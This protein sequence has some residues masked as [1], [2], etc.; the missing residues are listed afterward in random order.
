MAGGI[1]HDFNNA[2][3]SIIGYSELL[4]QDASLA[5]DRGLL[6]HYLKTMNTA[7]RDA[8]HVVSRL[9]D[10]YRPREESDVFT[11]VAIN[12][13]IKE[14]VPL[15][16]PKWHGQALETGRVIRLELDLQ[17][18]PH[19]LGNG[20]E[21]RETLMNL[22]FNAVDAM[23]DGGVITMRSE[24]HADTVKIEVAD[25]GVGMTE[26]VRQRC[27]EPFFSTKGV[28]GTGL[29]LA[30]VFGIIRRHE[31][32]LDID[33]TPGKGATFCLTLP[34]Y[35]SS[36]PEGEEVRL[37]SDRLLRILVV[38]DEPYAR[39]VVAQYLRTDGHRV[40]TAADGIEA[41]Q[42][43]VTED[44]DVVITD[45]GMPGM[46][47][48]QLAE[49]TRR[50]DPTKAII[51]LTGYTPDSTGQPGSVNCV[52]KKPFGPEELRAALVICHRGN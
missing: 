32:T 50:L 7:G 30:M 47:G 23:P 41:T 51:L 5:D 13:L 45:H 35:H 46:S 31:G 25:T 21:L 29:G 40:V 34:C 38:D 4:L 37:T 16:K 48:V 27:L 24:I 1:V 20:A 39:D 6:H 42:R 15:T 3:M 36:H 8:S 17:K 18:V 28:Q 11:A 22:I 2:L 26:E 33:S 10:F 44:F 49:T 9:R 14:I 19:V 43:V 52:L 12:D